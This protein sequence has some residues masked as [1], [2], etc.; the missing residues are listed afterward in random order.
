MYNYAGVNTTLAR[1]GDCG[2]IIVKV[3]LTMQSF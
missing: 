3:I 1:D 2:N